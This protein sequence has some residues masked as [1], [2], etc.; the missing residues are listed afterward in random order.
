MP[1]WVVVVVIGCKSAVQLFTIFNYDNNNCTDRRVVGGESCR[2]L[3]GSI[4]V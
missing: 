2:S 1:N 4:L 3:A